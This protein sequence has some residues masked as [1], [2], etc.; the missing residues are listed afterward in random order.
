MFNPE[1]DKTKK[2]LERQARK[3]NVPYYHELAKWKSKLDKD[4]D[5][6]KRKQDKIYKSYEIH[7]EL[8]AEYRKQNNSQNI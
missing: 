2:R 8:I 1:I 4:F 3:N 5:V 7:Q 6:I